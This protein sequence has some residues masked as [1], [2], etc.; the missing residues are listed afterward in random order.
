MGEALYALL[1]DLK[2]EL[3]NE[4]TPVALNDLHNTW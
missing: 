1:R 3:Q 4:G 2:E